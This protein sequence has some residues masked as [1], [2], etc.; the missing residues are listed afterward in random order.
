MGV[1]HNSNSDKNTECQPR[2]TCSWGK[3][4]I[5]LTFFFWHKEDRHEAKLTIEKHYKRTETLLAG[6]L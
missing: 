6:R 1:R 5:T 2:S 4:Q 3:F